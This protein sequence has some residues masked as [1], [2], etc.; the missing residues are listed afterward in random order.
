MYATP[1][2]DDGWLTKVHGH[3]GDALVVEAHFNLPRRFHD[4]VRGRESE[5]VFAARSRLARLGINITPLGDPVFNGRSC[6]LRLAV[7]AAIH[8]YGMAEHLDRLVVP[9]LAVGRLVF[10]PQ[11][12]RLSSTEIH[13][14]I[15]DNQ[16]QVPTGF[17]LDAHGYLILR[18]QQQVFRFRKPL[19]FDEVT[20]VANHA[21]GKEL[22]NRL[23]VR[24]AV[25]N[26]ELAPMDGLVT[27]CS[28]FLH[29]HYVVLQN[30]DD[31]LG[32]H[33]QATVLDPVSTRGTNVYLE[34][35]NRSDQLIVNPTVAATVH[36]AT[37]L[38]PEHR[39]WYGGPRAQPSAAEP[40]Y[41][42][43]LQV[44]D[45]LEASPLMTGDC[46]RL[47]AAT[48]D[49][50]ALL[51]G[52]APDLLC[53]R[54]DNPGS[55]RAAAEHYPVPTESAAPLDQLPD[56]AAATLLL[57]YFPN[58]IEHTE[59]CAAALRRKIARLCFRRPSFEHGVFLSDRDHGRLAD[60]EGLGLEV[61]WCNEAR[62]HVVRHAFRGLRGYFTTPD[63]LDRFRSALVFAIYGS[64]KPLSDQ[65][66][67]HTE[68]LIENLQGLFGNDIGILTGG[69][70]GSMQ[71]VTNTAHR[72]GLMAGSSFIETMDQETNKTADF[73]QTFQARSRQSRQRWFEIASFHIFLIGGVGT[74]EEIGLTLTDMKL[75]VIE[76][77]PVVFLDSSGG[78][79]YWEGLK[80]QLTRM[81]RAGRTPGWL[82]DNILMT[83]DPDEVPRFY[84][85]TLRLG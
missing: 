59:I 39:Y 46:H 73:Y 75:G 24:T 64:I 83:S 58:L 34:F 26:I 21:D 74:L 66:I 85:K 81:V 55:P 8:A 15:R 45:R 23:Q 80:T 56:G 6:D 5:L 19:T 41:R 11:D 9:G 79:F 60:Y 4:L 63:K 49:P 51:R 29:R 40:E 22:L 61:Y 31:S 37:R 84:K 27:A 52:A 72:L 50:A 36:E 17:S 77:S 2:T 1:E 38:E 57:G 68:R 69:G 28:M 43:L 65:E 25:D 14:L 30:L 70:P 71:Q 16:L 54:E 82:L 32:F 3:E 12:T 48:T 62:T 42:A 44:F 13:G 53:A 20:A 35:I 67:T 33:L 10:C 47:M 76:A 7:V 78:D 18:P